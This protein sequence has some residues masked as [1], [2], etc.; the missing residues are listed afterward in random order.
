M[1]ISELLG[2]YSY[3]YLLYVLIITQLKLSFILL[4][5]SN[6]KYIGIDRKMSIYVGS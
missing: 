4:L 2:D 3:S 5:L 1:S 6:S